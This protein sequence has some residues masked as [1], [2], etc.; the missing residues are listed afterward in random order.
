ML[1]ALAQITR[2][3]GEAAQRAG[4]IAKRRDNDIG[5]KC[6]SVLPHAPALIFEVGLL[7][8]DLELVLRPAR[9]DCVRRIEFGEMLPDN[10][11]GG[12]ALNLLCTAIPAAGSALRFVRARSRVV[13][14]V[15]LGT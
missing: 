11:R 5:P 13:D 6:R 15:R 3:L 2:D 10:F 4:L 7:G 9:P 14:L 8:G 1:L 12:V